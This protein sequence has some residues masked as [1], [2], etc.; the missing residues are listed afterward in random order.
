MMNKISDIHE[1]ITP[2]GEI[3]R[4]RYMRQRFEVSGK[5]FEFTFSDKVVD[6]MKVL[7]HCEREFYG[8][9]QEASVAT[10]KL[11]IK[12][13]EEYFVRY[14]EDEFLP[15]NPV[16]CYSNFPGWSEY[17]RGEKPK[18]YYPTWQE[19]SI[20]VRKEKIISSGQ[21]V[22]FCS[23]DPRLPTSPPRFYKDFPGWNV[24]LGRPS[25]YKTWQ[26]SSR[27]SI[28]LEIRSIRQYRER[29]KEDPKLP[30]DPARYYSDFPG[31]KMFLRGVQRHYPTWQ[32]ASSGAIKC[33]FI[34]GSDYENHYK[35]DLRLPS[36]P[37]KTYANFP[38][39]DIFLGRT[40]KP[41][42]YSELTEASEAAIKLKIRNSKEYNTK[43]HGDP[44]LPSNPQQ[45]YSNWVNWSKFL[46]NT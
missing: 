7:E 42:L 17:L 30:A 37:K 18:D 16:R 46:G 4:E 15:S 1:E 5:G 23:R 40:K 20:E 33:G 25:L 19:A 9:W 28:N 36:N 8:T 13:Q 21:Y 35:N 39:W 22:G 29:Y 14:I 31:Y 10:Q 45:K 24:F 27:A 11:K 38:G 44:K 32:E 41:E 43:H 6:L 2:R 26:D 3:E 12:T 34:S